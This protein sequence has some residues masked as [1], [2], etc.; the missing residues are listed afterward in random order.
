[1]NRG[2]ARIIEYIAHQAEVFARAERQTAEC[3]TIAESIV[4][5]KRYAVGYRHLGKLCAGESTLGYLRKCCSGG[6]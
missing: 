3:R 6:K 1:M 5:Y 2:K 4:I